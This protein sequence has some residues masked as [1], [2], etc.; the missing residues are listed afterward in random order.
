MAT[1]M[2]SMKEGFAKEVEVLKKKLAET[3]K[4]IVSVWDLSK[5]SSFSLE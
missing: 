3:E 4:R 2:E 1:E 5:T